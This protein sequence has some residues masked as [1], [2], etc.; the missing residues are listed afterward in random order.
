MQDNQPMPMNQPGMEE[1]NGMGAGLE[2]EEPMPEPVE[3]PEGDEKANSE[4]DDIFSKLDTEKQAAVIKYAK[5]MVDGD[6]VSDDKGDDM[7]TEITNSII[8]DK[9]V[10]NEGD[11]EKIRN[12]K[13]TSSNPF[14]T[15]QFNK[16]C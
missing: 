1:P 3:E 11:G 6:A 12:K 14:I 9:S 5:S 7:V 13:I 10:K 4:I 2:D 8:D 15:K 16:T